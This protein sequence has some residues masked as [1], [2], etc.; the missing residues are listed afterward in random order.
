MDTS[1]KFD[2]R[3]RQIV[4]ALTRG[5]SI[6]EC[7]RIDQPLM[8]NGQIA[9]RCRLPRSSV[10]RLTH[11]L[12]KQGYLEY[13]STNSAYQLGAK[14]LS[15]G[16]AM[17]G[18]MGLRRLALPYMEEL[19]RESNSLVALAACEN[20]NMLVIEVVRNPTSKVKILEVG[21]RLPLDSTAM[22]R[23]FLVSCSQVEQKK[24]LAQIAK[25]RNIDAQSLSDNIQSQ[26]SNYGRD[27]YCVS[28]NDWR[29]GANGVAV[30]LYLKDIGRRI[31]L[32]CGGTSK[33][34]TEKIIRRKIAPMLL[35]TAIEIE[36]I[37][38]KMSQAMFDGLRHR[39]SSS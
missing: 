28:L 36:T 31:V 30:P 38:K 32:T 37:H 20:L 15:L 11:T 12:V 27:G 9:T 7:F 6:L 33:Q 17:R 24:L 25:N 8:T 10:S 1:D 39:K 14:L 13:D 4:T 23:A 21:A 3:D 35:K 29:V 16:Y 18:G 26:I 34:L 2:S 19:A 5:L 22:G